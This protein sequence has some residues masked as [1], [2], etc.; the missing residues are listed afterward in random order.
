MYKKSEA[1]RLL[2]VFK[3]EF[4]EKTGREIEINYKGIKRNKLTLKGYAKRVCDSYNLKLED[5]I[6]PCRK[7]KLVIPRQIFCYIAYRE[8][9]EYTEIAEFIKRDRTTI[10]YSVENIKKTIGVDYEMEET[11]N[12]LLKVKNAY[13]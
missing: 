3:I 1:D 9:Y 8:G 7:D 5:L 10:Y 13:K 2:S 11:V 4:K 6:L 12:N